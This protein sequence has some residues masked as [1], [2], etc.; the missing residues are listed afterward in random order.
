MADP[1]QRRFIWNGRKFTVT[2]NATGGRRFRW[3]FETAKRLKGE[4]I[5]GSGL[6]AA[7]EAGRRAGK[8]AIDNG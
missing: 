2:V 7:F 8:L 4:S 6:E 5:S 3:R 1:L